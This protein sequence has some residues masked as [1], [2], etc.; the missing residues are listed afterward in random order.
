LERSGSLFTT[1][2]HPYLFRTT[3]ALTKTT[4]SFNPPHLIKM[5]PTCYILIGLPGSGKSTLAQQLLT[6]RPNSILVSTDRIRQQLYGDSSIQG[7]WQ[8]IEQQVLIQLQQTLLT[9]HPAIYDATNYN[10]RHRL[11]L[12]QKL[13]KL[14]S[15]QWIGLYLKTPV[16]QCKAWNRKRDRQVDEAVIDLM[17]QCLNESPPNI[18]EGFDKIYEIP[19]DLADFFKDFG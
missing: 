6:H 11:D 10:H 7:N 1:T 5:P 16:E 17:N 3:D 18:N 9:G 14:V 13:N 8:T 2:I 12:L 19:E 15:A 4:I